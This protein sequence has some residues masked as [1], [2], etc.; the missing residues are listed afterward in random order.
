MF[1][2]LKFKFDRAFRKDRFAKRVLEGIVS[3]LIDASLNL[4]EYLEYQDLLRTQEKY[5]WLDRKRRYE[6]K[7]RKLKSWGY[8]NSEEVFDAYFSTD[9]EIDDRLFEIAKDIDELRLSK[10]EETDYTKTINEFTDEIEA[11]EKVLKMVNKM[12]PIVI[13]AKVRK[14]EDIDQLFHESDCSLLL[15]MP[16]VIDLP[17]V[18]AK[19][20]NLL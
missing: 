3:A 9:T 8:K 16:S 14:L 20:Y 13:G 5:D 2:L 10:A 1:E 4:E 19:E 7:R 18:I 15:N 6:A 11:A 17:K 12:S